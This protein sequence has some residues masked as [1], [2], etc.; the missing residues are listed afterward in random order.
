MQERVLEFLLRNP[1]IKR[2]ELQK[3]FGDSVKR[4]LGHMKSRGLVEIKNL[5]VSLTTAGRL[6]ASPTFCEVCECDPCDC[7]WGQP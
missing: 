7:D 1:D 6:K 2:V 4:C 5:S 3:E